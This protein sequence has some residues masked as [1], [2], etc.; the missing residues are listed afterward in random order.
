MIIYKKIL[1]LFPVFFFL[2]M[3]TFAIGADEAY[4]IFEKLF[5]ELPM[6]EQSV[7]IVSDRDM[8]VMLDKTVELDMNLF[9]LLDCMYRYLAPRNKRLEISGTVIRNA[10]ASFSYGDPIEYLLPIE[11]LIK[12]QVGACFTA[13]QKPVDMRLYSEYSTYIKIAT[14][15]YDTQCGFEK[16]EPHSFL[17]PYGMRIKKWNIVKPVQKLHLFEP[18]RGAI[19]AKGFFKPKTWY[20]DSV[21]R[22]VQEE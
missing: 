14:A 6:Q 8:E 4:P 5:T 1:L 18:G 19:Y 3:H 9:E 11:K 2:L 20:L 17:Q 7:Y 10:Q 21:T 12:V 16:V 13:E 15:V 22:I